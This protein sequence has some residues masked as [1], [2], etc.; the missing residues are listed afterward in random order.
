M[1]KSARIALDR[2]LE[3]FENHYEVSVSESASDE[4]LA[5]AELQ[6]RN[7]FFTYDDE[8]FTEYDVELPFDILDEDDDEDDDDYDFYDID[9]E[10]DDED[11][12]DEE[13]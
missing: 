9:D 1:S 3:A 2:L 10:D 13:D 8:L 6:L 7:A 11:D 5:R 12:E 4:A